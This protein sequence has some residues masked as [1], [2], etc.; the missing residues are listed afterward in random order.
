M[1]DN[2]KLIEAIEQA[3]KAI[4]TA[5]EQLNKKPE[6]KN[7][8]EA[9]WI[10]M[11]EAA[12]DRVLDRREKVKRDILNPHPDKIIRGTAINDENT[13][14]LHRYFYETEAQDRIAT[15]AMYEA[16]SDLA[17]KRS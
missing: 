1:Q 8:T 7:E 12:V 15:S 10:E 9:R 3:Q 11:I 4:D 5:V 6:P 14:S 2:T 16:G 17:K 13:M